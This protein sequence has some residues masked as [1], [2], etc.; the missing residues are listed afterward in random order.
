MGTGL[1]YAAIVA[2]WL[3]YLIPLYLKRQA[4]DELDESDP[5]SRFSSSIRIIRES[6]R[7]T[8]DDEGE[9]IDEVEVSTPLTRRA[10]LASVRRSEIVAAH[11]RRVVLVTLFALLT[12]AL[13]LSVA[14]VLPYWTIAVPGALLAAFV[15]V[16][17]YS[18]T[19]MRKTLDA[20]V[21]QIKLA[22]ADEDETVAIGA[23]EL[24]AAGEEKP[25]QVKQVVAGLWD[26]I[27]VTLPTYV[28]KPLAPRTVRTIDLSG[29]DLTVKG[30]AEDVPPTA[31]APVPADADEANASDGSGPG[32]SN[33]DFRR[34]S[35]S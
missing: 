26:P 32:R 8:R 2:A 27:P 11:R 35:G 15:G 6:T 34:A 5:R 9:P 24:R 29:P 14:G 30:T 18:V 1:I 22:A 23:D 3:M 13:V 20:R 19:T 33:E 16:A 31:D 10:A 25:S 21:A 12:L 4:G 7:T 28:S 17:R